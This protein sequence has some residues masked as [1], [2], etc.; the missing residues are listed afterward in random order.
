MRDVRLPEIGF[1]TVGRQKLRVAHW[2]GEG[3]HHHRPVLFFNGIGANLE[4]VQPLAE[5]LPERDIITFDMPGIGGSPAPRLPYRPWWVAYAANT[6][7][8]RFGFG[9]VDVIGV[10]WGGGAAQQFAFQYR[11]RTKRLVLAATSAG[12]TMVPGSV[13]VLSKMTTPAR[14]VD[15]D[16]L[17]KN[18][19]RLYG[20]EPGFMERHA[21]RIT[22]PKKRGYAAQ[23]AAMAGWTS[24]PFLPLLPQP[25]LVLMGDRDRIVPV[26]N[27]RILASMIPN[28]K[29][30]IVKGGGHLFIVT[31]LPEITPVLRDFLDD[32]ALSH[33]SFDTAKAA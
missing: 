18:F 23:L 16:Y 17:A 6:I 21:I 33:R 4:L 13:D 2:K 29:L 31:R 25:T 32:G 8:S 12:W 19:E 15:P 9:P 1:E 24:L 14:Y 3:P 11:R 5:A 7:L 20:D 27:G 10:S 30:H 22:P 28:A 26:I